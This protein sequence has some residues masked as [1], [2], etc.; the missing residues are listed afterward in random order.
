MPGSHSS[1][2]VGLEWERPD[3]HVQKND[4]NL[5]PGD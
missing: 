3:A 2:E 1:P 4:T 5:I